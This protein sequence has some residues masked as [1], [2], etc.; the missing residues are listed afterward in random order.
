VAK[1]YGAWGA[2]QRAGRTSEGIVRSSFLIDEQGKIV[3]AWYQ[4]APEATVPNALNL[5]E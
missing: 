1:A 3:E 4:V 2:K 5:I